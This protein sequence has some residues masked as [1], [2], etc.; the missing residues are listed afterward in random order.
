MMFQLA[1]EAT[2]YSLAFMV[3]ASLYQML[4]TPSLG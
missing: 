2:Q 1:I 4:R 3:A